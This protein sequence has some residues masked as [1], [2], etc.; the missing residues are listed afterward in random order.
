MSRHLVP[1]LPGPRAARR[2][3]E[4]V[5]FLDPHL[6]LCECGLRIVNGCVS[7]SSRL[8]PF[9]L[10]TCGLRDTPT[11][12]SKAEPWYPATCFLQ[13]FDLL[14][15]RRDRLAHG[16]EQIAPPNSLGFSQSL[17]DIERST[18]WARS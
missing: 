10:N 4:P 12:R 3:W 11:G 7:R 17:G 16:L 2:L 8:S 6:L 13:T 9:D 18:R 5:S 14:P 1:V 15:A